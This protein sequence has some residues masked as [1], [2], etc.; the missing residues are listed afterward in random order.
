MG[1]RHVKQPA[2]VHPES[3]GQKAARGNKASSTASASLQG[4]KITPD[5]GIPHTL[6]PLKLGRWIP[7]M[8][9]PDTVIPL[10]GE[11]G[12]VT[13]QVGDEPEGSNA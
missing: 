3:D 4:R 11:E 1:H 12:P 10:T 2:N 5:S 6:V 7:G 9:K 8:V 13:D